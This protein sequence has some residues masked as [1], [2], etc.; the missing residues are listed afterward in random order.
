MNLIDSDII[1]V[2]CER[3]CICTFSF[4]ET[5]FGAWRSQFDHLQLIILKNGTKE[6][7]HNVIHFLLIF[8]LWKSSCINKVDTSLTSLP[9]SSFSSFFFHAF[10]PIHMLCH[11]QWTYCDTSLSFIFFPLSRKTICLSPIMRE[12][13]TRYNKTTINSRK[14]DD[15]LG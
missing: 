11:F 7:L 4:N 6:W 2:D 5:S 9:F 3:V 8:H 14:I 10:M 1:D 15:T 12:E 13:A